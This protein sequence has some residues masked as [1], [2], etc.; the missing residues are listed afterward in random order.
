MVVREATSADVPQLVELR[1]KLF[2]ELGEI[3]SNVTAPELRE[4]T[5]RFFTDAALTGQSKSWIAVD[6]GIVVASGTLATFYRP[7]YLGNLSGHEGV[8][9]ICIHFLLTVES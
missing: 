5:E 3:Q 9:L 1:M 4:A 8:C 7:P 2:A 6:D